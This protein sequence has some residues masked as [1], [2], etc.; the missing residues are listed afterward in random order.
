MTKALYPGSFDPITYGHVDIIR[1]AVSIF[2]EVV[3]AVMIND[4]KK[5]LF[6]TEERLDML[7]HTIGALPQVSIVASH[8]LTVDLAHQVN[9]KVLIRGIRAVMDYEYELQ[10]ST[11]N[12][13]LAEDIETVFLLSKPD[14]SFLSSSGAKTVARYQGDLHKFVPPY[15]AEQLQKKLQQHH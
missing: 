15:V 8:G 1:R 14:Y 10:Q 11:I 12:M 13:M 9:A 2:D 3:V 7:R 6:T 5:P 4:E